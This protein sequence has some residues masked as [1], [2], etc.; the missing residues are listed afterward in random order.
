MVSLGTDCLAGFDGSGGSCG[1]NVTTG[2]RLPGWNTALAA[3]PLGK[4][5]A[6]ELTAI[7][8]GWG[9]DPCCPVRK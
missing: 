1:Y 7:R 5:N 4:Y 2:S 9:E 8:Y 6:T 3:L